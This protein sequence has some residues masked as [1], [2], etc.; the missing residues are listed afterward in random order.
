MQLDFGLRD[1]INPEERIW[2]KFLNKE[3][4]SISSSTLRK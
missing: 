2:I 3:A 1:Q 4:K